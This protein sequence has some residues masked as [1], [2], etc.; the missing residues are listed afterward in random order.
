MLNELN[1]LSAMFNEVKD[2]ESTF[3]GLSDGTYDASVE[4][5]KLTTSKAGRPMV[6]IDFEII[7]GDSKGA[8]HR[9]F[10]MLVGNDEGQTKQNLN[11]MATTVRKLGVDTNG[12]EL[13]DT[14]DQFDG[15]HGI[16]VRLELVTT[17]SRAGVEWQN[18]SFEVI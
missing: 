10:L 15:L 16:P 11:R 2:E 12:K 6:T 7:D 4:V 3:I 9:Q 8:T 14:F 5:V 17:K 13:S 18:T 1:E